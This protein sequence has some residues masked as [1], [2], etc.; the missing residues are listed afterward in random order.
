MEAVG[1]ASAICGI[2]AAGIQ[3]SI[4]L[5][6]L[7]GLVKSAQGDITDIAEGVLLNASILQQLGELAKIGISH[8]QTPLYTNGNNDKSKIPHPATGGDA[9]GS[10]EPQQGIFNAAGLAVILELVTECNDIFS[11]LNEVVR[12]TSKELSGNTEGQ[13]R[14]KSTRAGMVKWPFTMPQIESMR[15]RLRD[16]KGTLM[17][18]LQVAMLRDS[19]KAMEG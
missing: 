1:S 7:A 6:A 16:A 4:K 5:I 18:M 14:I 13:I 2:A 9:E 3:C 12:E 17:L 15:V 8:E 11:T 10:T 19:E